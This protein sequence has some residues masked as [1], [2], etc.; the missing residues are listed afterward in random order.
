MADSIE[1]MQTNQRQAGQGLSQ[2]QSAASLAHGVLTLGAGLGVAAVPAANGCMAPALASPISN[3]KESLPGPAVLSSLVQSG[4]ALG[5]SPSAS[6][7][8][9]N[10]AA[11]E[12]LRAAIPS[13]SR[14]VDAFACAKEKPIDLSPGDGVMRTLKLKL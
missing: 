2:A 4:D 6:L 12:L 5:M 8:C 9:T 13:F 7:P 11:Y 14:C 1:C 3:D 10:N